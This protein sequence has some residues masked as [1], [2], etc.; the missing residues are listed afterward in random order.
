VDC[1]TTAD[2]CTGDPCV[3]A[4]SL[5]VIASPCVLDFGAATLQIDKKIRVAVD[6]GTLSLTA[7]NII[8]DDKIDAKHVKAA[9]GTGSSVSLISP[10]NITINRKI[11]AAARNTPGSISIDAGGNVAINHQ[12]RARAKGGNPPAGGGT[13]T[14]EVDGTV[15]S[16]KRGKIDVRGKKK[17]T[18]GGQVDITAELGATLKGR[19]EAR[20][21]DGGTVAV[22]IPNG[23]LTIEEEVRVQGE[24]GTGGTAIL[25][26]SGDVVI[27]GKKGTVRARGGATGAGG[28]TISISG[29]TVS[30]RTLNAKSGGLTTGGTIGIVGGTVSAERLIVN[31]GDGGTVN[32]TSTVGPVTISNRILVR[33]QKN[34]GGSASVDSASDATIEA[35]LD[36]RGKTAGGTAE[37][38]AAGN[39]I[40]G[41]NDRTKLR[42]SSDVAGGAIEATAGGNLT[43]RGKYEVEVGG[44]IGLSAGGTLDTTQATFDT[45]PVGSCP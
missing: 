17:G 41:K 39:M 29:A 7:A 16:I 31:G 32:V 22:T 33:G 19:I 18:V 4:D 42:A 20:G 21:L 11:D 23:N 2:F 28:G 45:T 1:D 8:I 27:G 43:V 34:V 14:I 35:L 13:V 36:A 6:G 38:N 10:G 12:L 15:S 30:V 44:C 26:A 40:L 9:E 5:E 3:T 37:Y 25:D 24:F